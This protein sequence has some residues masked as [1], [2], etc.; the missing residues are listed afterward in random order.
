[1]L[2]PLSKKECIGVD[3]EE[4]IEDDSSK[5][6]MRNVVSSKLKVDEIDLY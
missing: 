6:K 4:K 2:I 3:I 5:D 1:M